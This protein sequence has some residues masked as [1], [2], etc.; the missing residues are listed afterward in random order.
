MNKPLH[1]VFAALAAVSAVA[2]SMPASA[3]PLEIT[4]PGRTA[5]PVPLPPS[6]RA[7][8]RSKL[9]DYH[10]D[11]DIRFEPGEAALDALPVVRTGPSI[12]PVRA[13]LIER[14]GLSLAQHQLRCQ[15]LYRT[16]EPV[17]DTYVGPDGIP[18]NCVY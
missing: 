4:V 16:Y 3:Q 17:S 11:F 10:L 2:A 6:D 18:R 5:E 14:H 7:V 9:F 15:S 12:N 8:Q 1:I 13:V